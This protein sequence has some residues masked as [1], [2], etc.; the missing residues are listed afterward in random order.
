MALCSRCCASFPSKP[1]IP[2]SPVPELIRTYHPPSSFQIRSIQ[3][4]I[5]D[6]QSH[7]CKLDDEIMKLENVMD[8]LRRRRKAL[9]R[10]TQEHQAVL[11][12]MRRLP[13]ELLGDIFNLCLN[14]L[15]NN[16]F[17]DPREAPLLLSQ[18][19]IGWR[20]AAL[21]NAK[22][23][24]TISLYLEN[25]ISES[26]VALVKT[27]L[28]RAGRHPL[29]IRI[30]DRWLR[31]THPVLDLISSCSDR[32]QHVELCV[33]PSY[34]EN[35]NSGLSALESASFPGLVKMWTKPINIFLSAPRFHRLHI[36]F[37][38]SPYMMRVPWNQLT[39]LR[40]DL[41][42]FDG[43]IEIIRQSPNLIHCYLRIASWESI[44]PPTCQILL[45]QL[46]FLCVCSV[47][48]LGDLLDHLTLPALLDIQLEQYEGAT[49]TPW[50][51][52]VI[53]LLH[54]SSCSIK[55]LHVD[56]NRRVSDD[57]LVRCLQNM[58][59]VTTLELGG[60]RASSFGKRAMT[61][62]TRNRASEPSHW[63]TLPIVPKLQIIKLKYDN[64]SAFDDVAFV[65]MVASRWDFG[66]ASLDGEV[67]RL[68]TVHVSIFHHSVDVS[69][70][71]L[72]RLRT[73]QDNGLDIC[74]RY[75]SSDLLLLANLDV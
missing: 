26:E 2:P 73:F 62:L 63:E 27:W 35:L 22:L 36:C 6:V 74:L 42:Q 28:G 51:D 30:V 9:H 38:I 44:P 49:E 25:P 10:F 48:N 13:P 53:S 23:W 54:R 55:R 52:Q 45:S 46:R 50:V 5:S 4:S 17:F 60:Y 61:K 16:R 75:E 47:S 71:S 65:D 56:C 39:H 11:S 68:K 24:S 70:V 57:H 1:D 31:E 12:P 40:V 37:P 7:L 14:D 32:W 29:S 19:C 66:A 21:S 20:E 33:A 58:P 67:A 43:C 15:W 69:L 8:N 18:V 64:S 3:Q 34:F 59:S 41:C 72:R